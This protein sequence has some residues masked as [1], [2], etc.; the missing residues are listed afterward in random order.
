M[1]R[2]IILISIALMI[3]MMLSAQKTL[4]ASWVIVLFSMILKYV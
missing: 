2:R 4:T 3:P 1:L